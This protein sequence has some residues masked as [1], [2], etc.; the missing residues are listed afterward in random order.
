MP[1]NQSGDNAVANIK[2]YND[3]NGTQYNDNSTVTNN[4]V[5][6]NN[7]TNKATTNSNNSN[8]FNQSTGGKFRM[9]FLVGCAEL[10][11][12]AWVYQFA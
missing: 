10:S 3:V 2:T 1:F 12:S 8:S 6:S 9:L 11:G 4:N 7:K 5:N